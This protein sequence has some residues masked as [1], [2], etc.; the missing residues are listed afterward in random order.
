VDRH[1]RE[2]AL[3]HRSFDAMAGILGW[4]LGLVRNEFRDFTL[5]D[6]RALEIGTGKFLN[7][8]IALFA[9]GCREVVSVDKHRQIQPE[10]VKLAASRP[11][12]ARRFLSGQ[13]NHDH[14]TRRMS[15]ARNTAFDLDELAHLG[16][17][18]KAPFDLACSNTFHDRFDFVFSYTVFEHVPAH[19]I[20]PLLSASLSA[21][22]AGG[23]CAHFVDLEDHL[24][25]ETNPFAFLSE[26]IAWTSEE[27]FQRGN[28]LR[29]SSW[30]QVFSRQ[31]NTLWRYPYVATRNDAPLPSAIAAPIAFIDEQDLRAAALLAVGRKGQ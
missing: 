8:A 11:V 30:R 19:E 13:A 5:I 22:K 6:A 12:L 1:T 20:D 25:P 15:L 14:F 23:I 18:Y 29:L 4:I 10:A 7:H 2:A 31:T 21:L 24:A 9:C 17:L 27:T 3:G 16:I 26:E 28:R